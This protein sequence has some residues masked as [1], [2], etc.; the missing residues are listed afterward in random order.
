VQAKKSGD[1]I[2]ALEHHAQAAKLY[3][4]I[5]VAIKDQ[6]GKSCRD[7]NFHKLFS[8]AFY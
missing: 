7:R 1:L 5:A 8:T 6:N 3:R 4:E 2:A